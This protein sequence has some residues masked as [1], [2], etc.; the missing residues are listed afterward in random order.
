MK[1][2]K[3]VATHFD[4]EPLSYHQSAGQPHPDVSKDKKCRSLKS[5]VLL[6]SVTMN[7]VKASFERCIN[8]KSVITFQQRQKFTTKDKIL[9][10][11]I[12]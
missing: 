2:Q 6:H 8:S 3:A 11:K 4:S 7:A 9:F 10:Q 1:V 5:F 12:S